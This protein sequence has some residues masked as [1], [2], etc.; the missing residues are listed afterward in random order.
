MSVSKSLIQAMKQNCN[1]FEFCLC[2][3]LVCLWSTWNSTFVTFKPTFSV[4]ARGYVDLAAV[5]ELA[6][7]H[8]AALIT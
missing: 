1:A 3:F 2:A 8:G 6:R 4:I 7:V 5:Q